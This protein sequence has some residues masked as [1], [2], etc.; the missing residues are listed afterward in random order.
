M[1]ETPKGHRL[2]MEVFDEDSL[3]HDEFLGYVMVN[4][5]DFLGLEEPKTTTMPLQDDPMENK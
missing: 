1:L 5:E 4:V 3:S 2:R